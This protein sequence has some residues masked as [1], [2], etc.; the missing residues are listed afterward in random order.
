VS[1]DLHDLR[2]YT[3]RHLYSA[4]HITVR[5]YEKRSG[6][7]FSGTGTGFFIEAGTGLESFH[8]VTARHVLDPDHA[9]PGSGLRQLESITVRGVRTHRHRDDTEFDFTFTPEHVAFHPDTDID[10]AV[11]RVTPDG[12][13][14]ANVFGVAMDKSD[15]IKPHAILADEVGVGTEIVMVGYPRLENGIGHRPLL[16]P[17]IVSS[18]LRYD[19]DYGANTY[20]GRGICHSF[21][22]GGMSGA[23]VLTAVLQ[24]VTWDDEGPREPAVRLLGINTGHPKEKERPE[25]LSLFVPATALAPL[26]GDDLDQLYQRIASSTA[27]MAGI[28]DTTKLNRALQLPPRAAV[29]AEVAEPDYADDDLDDYADDMDQGANDEAGKA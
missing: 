11:V 17:G 27:D 28:V 14:A 4:V 25:A 10:L 7:D 29:P 18:D 8:L 24:S 1:R 9:N 16:V 3:R 22:R 26:I 2:R 20:P 13:D 19:A 23:P 21:S 12:K 5:G 15:I 6:D